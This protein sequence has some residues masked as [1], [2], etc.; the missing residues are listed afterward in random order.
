LAKAIK[1]IAVTGRRIK[2]AGG[3]A[4]TAV[5]DRSRAAGK[6]AH[7]IAAKLRMCSAQGRDDAQAVVKRITGE[8]ADLAVTAAKDAQKTLLNARRTLRRAQVKAQQL[9]PPGWRIQSRVADE[10][11]CTGR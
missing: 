5:R 1:R 8:L 4:R 7:G 9:A 2:A 10:D 3:A 6:R 11:G